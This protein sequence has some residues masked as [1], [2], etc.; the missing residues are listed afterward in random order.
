MNRLYFG[1]DGIRG[2]VGGPVMNPAFLRRVGHA[3]GRYLFE[4]FPNKPRH[5]VIGRDTRASGPALAE[6]LTEGLSHYGV[7]LYDIGVVPTPAIAMV[8]RDL[9]ADLGL[10]LTASHNPAGDNGLKVFGE[11]GHKLTD[12]HEARVEAYLDEVGELAA[13]PAGRGARWPY[14]GAAFYANFIR[15]FL[16]E[17]CLQGWT[18]VVDTA[19]GASHAVAPAVLRQLGARVVQLGGAPDGLNINAGVGSEHPEAMAE[20]VRRERAHLGL[21]FDGDADRLVVA[22]DTGALVD[23]DEL[24]ALIGLH[25]LQR[26]QLGAKTL[27]ATV[28]SNLGLDAALRQAGGTVRRA[29]VGDRYVLQAMRESGSTF[30]GENSGHLIFSDFS[31]A[32]DGLLAAIKLIEVLLAKREPLSRLRGAVRLYPQRKANLRLAEKIPFAELPGWEAAVAAIAAPLGAEGRVLVRYS[33][34]E[35][36]LRL[37]AEAPSAEAADAALAALKTLAARHLR[38]L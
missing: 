4:R 22:D 21:A 11:A 35:P 28:M 27:V 24:L 30:G 17:G 2:T 26:G 38:L 7:R 31:T 14:D 18:V 20:A 29:A 36:K 1:T 10:V 33:G 37:L 12:E 32:G 13:D 23:G 19:N 6:A 9:H 3:L 15:S 16:D 25:L 34:T 8:L 5:A